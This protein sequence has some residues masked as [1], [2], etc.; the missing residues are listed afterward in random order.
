MPEASY[1]LAAKILRDQG[2]GPCFIISPLLV[3][4]RNQMEA[5]KQF[6]LRAA[7]I[8]SENRD[9]WETVYEKL[10]NNQIDVLFVSP[11]RLANADF[12]HRMLQILRENISMLVIDEAHCISDW[13]HDF[14]PDYLRI[15]KIVQ[16]LPSNIPLLAT[17]ATANNRVIED[18]RHQFDD[19]LHVLRGPLA[20]ESLRIQ[21]LNGL[22]RKEDRLAWLAENLT[23]LHGTGIIY[24]LT[25]QDCEM[26][27][28]WLQGCGWDVA[29][30][31]AGRTDRHELED[32]FFHNQLKAL[33]ATVAL[34]M[35]VDKPD[36][37]FVIHFQ[38]PPNIIAYYQQIGRAGR[39]GR[40]AYAILMMG[41]EDESINQ[42]FIYSAFPQE[43][44]TRQVLQILDEAEDGLKKSEI[45]G[46]LNL[47]N[48]KIEQILKLLQIGDFIYK[49]ASRY[50][51]STKIWQPEAFHA[52]RLT[53]LRQDELYEMK[54]YA[55][56]TGCYMEYITQSLNDPKAHACAKCGNCQPESRF[57][58]N[59]R[60]ESVQA[61]GLF[62]RSHHVVIEPRKQWGD[63]S[64]IPA[65]MRL[66]P[67]YALSNYADAGWGKV[68]K[69]DKYM[70]G[71]FSSELIGAA[72]E[73]L[74]DFCREREIDMVTAVPSLR[75]PHL[76]PDFAKAVAERLNLLYVDGLVKCKNVPEQK[77]QKN[78][79]WQCR[80]AMD[81]FA[82]IK[83]YFGNVL[84]IDDM[85]DSRWTL[86]VCGVKIMNAGASKVFPFALANSG[87]RG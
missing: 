51:R 75:H 48:T 2:K 70:R 83:P 1:F 37:R 28:S 34:G 57:P 85:V 19:D 81:S 71:S 35:G 53:K 44:E 18:I 31:H 82:A 69:A 50:Y 54:A 66:Q 16:L 21:V 22:H 3:L 32:R 59:V 13:G 23:R 84:L 9:D 10:G 46:T 86:T 42:Y 39:D 80:N 30:Y 73:M 62:L 33:V 74:R 20:R 56:T 65:D 17:T 58:T 43:S 27:A 77:A 38:M 60:P 7:T 41:D 15:V 67:G 36:I 87:T 6:C 14:R 68:V 63:G 64:R 25:V 76:V 47:S 79:A 61:A 26:V 52:R 24:C 5:A 72:V 12:M 4:M 49:D 78:S 29:P 8:N 11:E 40:D 55:R 45:L